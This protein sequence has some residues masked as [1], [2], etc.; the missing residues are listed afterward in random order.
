MLSQPELYDQVIDD[1]LIGKNPSKNAIVDRATFLTLPLDTRNQEESKFYRDQ[2]VNH[3]TEE[4]TYQDTKIHSRFI[5]KLQKQGKRIASMTY[6]F[7][8]Y[9]S[10]SPDGSPEGR[11]LTNLTVR[12][13]DVFSLD[14]Q[15][16]KY[17]KFGKGI[18]QKVKEVIAMKKVSQELENRKA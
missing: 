2:E 12:S 6:N 11:R 16:S 5:K 9:R 10:S 3:L 15:Y 17:D 13:D 8:S 7:G 4:F 1:I 14:D 18:K